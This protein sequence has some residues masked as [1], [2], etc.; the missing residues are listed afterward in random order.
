MFISYWEDS[1]SYCGFLR[2]FFEGRFLL[3]IGLHWVGG[4]VNQ[5][6]GAARFLVDRLSGASLRSP[7]LAPVGI[8]AFLVCGHLASSLARGCTKRRSARQCF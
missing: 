4:P 8:P 1:P 7:G 3:P 6:L 2:T 5:F